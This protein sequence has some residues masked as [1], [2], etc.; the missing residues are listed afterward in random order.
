[1]NYSICGPQEILRKNRLIDNSNEAKSEYWK[2][3]EKC[4]EG[5]SDA[6]GCYVF[7]LQNKP[8][9]IGMASKQS[10]A[11]ECFTHHKIN[12]YNQALSQYKRAV[13]VLY[14]LAKMTPS[15]NFSQPSI[16]GHYDIE[17][18]EKMLIGMGIN[19]NSD[20]MNIKGTKLLRELNIPGII[21]TKKG[22]GRADVVRDL[23]DIFGI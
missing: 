1:M 15:G 10:Y 19:R 14:F 2:K 20:L 7:S 13:P 12:L 21:N 8:W 5:L 4:E 6:C 9:Y 22:Q 11:Q 17:F 3:I 16:N 23:R 18:L